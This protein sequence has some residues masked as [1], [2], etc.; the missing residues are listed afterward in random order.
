MGKKNSTHLQWL[1]NEYKKDEVELLNEKHK[2]INE[3][4]QLKKEDII[5]QKPKKV[6]IWARIM[7]VLMS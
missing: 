6:S 5:P 4:K 2:I 3:I 7:R 1:N